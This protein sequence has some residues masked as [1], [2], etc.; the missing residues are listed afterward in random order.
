MRR[1]LQPFD[2]TLRHHLAYQ[3]G[4][5]LFLGFSLLL[6]FSLP[7]WRLHTLEA[8]DPSFLG[9]PTSIRVG[10]FE[11]VDPL[12]GLAT[13]LMRGVS[14]NLV[15]TLLPG[16]LLVGLLGRFFCGWAC[17]YLPVLAASNAAR[18]LLSR[19]GLPTADVK[20]P[21]VTSRVVLVGVLVV[22]SV[23]GVQVVPLVYPPAVIGREAFRVVF[24]GSLG[25][26][27]F[28]VLA[29]FLFD[30]FVSR[31]GFC[32][33]LCP[34]GA[35][36]STLGAASPIKVHNDRS[37]CTDCTVCDVVCNLGQS[38]MQNKVDSGCERCGKCI[39][40]CPTKALSWMLQVPGKK[41]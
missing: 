7:L 39:A 20:L 14:W 3:R 11:L 25:A 26:G 21:R 37:K 24:Y 12:E 22:G 35:M 6:T 13:A 36:F 23:L 2:I 16:V 40:S 33:S 17:P 10:F 18:W 29:A 28:V 5:Q 31:A 38:P 30:T 27:A 19:L 32:R 34:G 8:N 1:T 9:A 4:R 41:S 15:W